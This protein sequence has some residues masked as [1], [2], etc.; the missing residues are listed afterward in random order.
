MAHGDLSH[1]HEA[2]CKGLY[3]FPVL[4]AV[5]GLFIAKRLASFRYVRPY[6]DL[7]V[8]TVLAYRLYTV[9]DNVDLLQS[10]INEL[11]AVAKFTGHVV[12]AQK[13]FFVLKDILA[14]LL[15]LRIVRV[16]TDAHNAVT[17][18]KGFVPLYKDLAQFGYN[19]VKSLSFVRA[20]LE[21]ETSKLESSMELELKVK[22]RELGETN[23][24]LPQKGWSKKEVL[25]LMKKA[26]EKE[27]VVWEEGN[28]SGAVYHGQRGH[29]EF[30]NEAYS[31]YSIANPLHP[32]IWPSVMKFEAEIISMTANMVNGGDTGVCGCT[33]SGGTES[34]ILAIK[35]HR[36]YYRQKY[37][38]TQPEM[39]CGLSAHAAVDK[40]CD[41]LGIKLIKVPLDDK[42]RVDVAAVYRHINSNTILVY[43]SAPSYPQ[44]AVDDIQALGTICR[45]HDVGLHVDC[46]L[47]GFVLPFARDAGMKVPVFDFSVRGVT[48]MSLDTHK[49]GYAL[50]GASVVLYRNKELRHAQY[51]CYADWTGGMY[52]TPTVA[53]SRSGGLIAQCWASMMVMGQQTYQDMAVKIISLAREITAQVKDIE[54]LKLCGDCDAMIVCVEGTDGINIYSVGDEMHKMGWSLNALQNPASLHLCVTVT[55]LHR[56]DKFVRDL[57][58]AVQRVR[59][60]GTDGQGEGNAAIY[61]MTSSLPPGPVN[62]ILKTYNDVVLKL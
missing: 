43:A 5:L 59:E 41:M 14:I 51:F 33:T 46:C 37:D 7:L 58:T 26:T 62:E 34:I 4:T 44:G 1:A 61:G 27:D 40:A 53:G 11:Q 15:V 35:T 3:G 45:E 13:V 32:D 56:G 47:G 8:V 50:K 17:N 31:Y 10:L 21:K 42:F 20:I 9:T 25:S 23:T 6:I 19:Q 24:K 18:F 48:S 22:S 60:R 38:I 30:L 16:L 55:H 12:Y 57:R 52:T 36:D 54:G 49:Y 39:I 28:V 29:I 2:C